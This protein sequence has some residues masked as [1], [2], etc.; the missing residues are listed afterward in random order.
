[1]AME[2]REFVA[3][4]GITAAMPSPA[5]TQPSHA[6]ES[7]TGRLA[8][9]WSFVSSINTRK[10]G[11]TFDRWGMNPKGILM[12]DRG[13]YYAQIIVGSASRVFGSKT[14][15]A[16]GTY[17]VDETKGALITHIEGCPF[18]KC[19][20]VWTRV[21]RQNHR[22]IL[23]DVCDPPRVRNVRRRPV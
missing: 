5:R 14:F 16:F 3:L 17:S 9:S 20:P 10:D 22:I 2:R 4:L 23:G 7:F 6:T 21:V 12:F 8:G 18:R 11:S 1:M 13:G 19:H 15:F